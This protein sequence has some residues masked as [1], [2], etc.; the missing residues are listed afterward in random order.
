MIQKILNI[1][2]TTIEQGE[3]E[4]YSPTTDKKT[5]IRS[6]TRT[7]NHLNLGSTLP[8]SEKCGLEIL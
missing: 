5:P 1:Y 2:I 8:I 4:I 7:E 3:R 6:K